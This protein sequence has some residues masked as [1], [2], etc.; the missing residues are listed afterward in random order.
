[1][2]GNSKLLGKL[3]GNS[4][5]LLCMLSTPCTAKDIEER[6]KLKGG[7]AGR[8]YITAIEHWC[9]SLKDRLRTGV[10]EGRCGRPAQT[11]WLDYL[12]EKHEK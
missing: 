2:P 11:W 10:Q 5:E 7:G 9:P 8:S 4:L 6:L 1:M 3:I 12:G